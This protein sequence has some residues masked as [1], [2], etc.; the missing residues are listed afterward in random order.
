MDQTILMNKQAQIDSIDWYHEF[1]FGDGLH[2]RSRSQAELH[3]PVWKF[4][5][6]E[7]DRINFKDQS[8]LEIG[9]WDGYW[10]FYAERRGAQHV[11]AT[12]DV[13]QNWANGRGIH[14]AKELL[15]SNVEINQN[16]SIYEASQL[17]QTFDVI[18]CLGVYYHL[19]DPFAGIAQLRHLMHKNS[20]VVFEGDATVALRPDTYYWELSDSRRSSFIPTLSGFNHML[21]AAYLDVSYQTWMSPPR[22]NMLNLDWKHIFGPVGHRKSSEFRELKHRQ[23]LF[24]IARPYSGENELHFYKPPF[25]LAQFDTR[26]NDR[27]I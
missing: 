26:F 14:L 21:K 22:K 3:R 23:K 16:V 10:S 15:N 12:D 7:L 11:L 1:D 9:S 18:L 25:G 8:V 5:E 2:A 19:V 20:I 4:I 13:S 24:T 17:N 6:S 27:L